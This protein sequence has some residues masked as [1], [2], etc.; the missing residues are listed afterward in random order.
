MSDLQCM[1]TCGLAGVMLFYVVSIVALY[2]GGTRHRAMKRLSVGA[3]IVSAALLGG[4]AV[5]N[6]AEL[7]R[8]RQMGPAAPADP[9]LAAPIRGA[10]PV[11]SD[12]SCAA[13]S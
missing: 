6:P 5:A 4:L 3:V 12:L 9:A 8:I 7:K 1:L 10:V 13:D 2:W 11:R